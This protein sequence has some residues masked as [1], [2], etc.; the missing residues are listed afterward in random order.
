MQISSELARMF[1]NQ[2][3]REYH[4]ELSYRC[5]ADW[6]ARHGL[7]NIFKHLFLQADDEHGHALKFIHY[8]DEANAPLEVPAVVA[9]SSDYAD[10]HAIAV[11]RLELESSTKDEID[12]IMDAA[13]QEGDY[14]AQTFLQDMCL[15]QVQEVTESERFVAALECAGGAFLLDL[16]LK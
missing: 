1:N 5:M 10:C 9:A 3:S 2:I 11:A 14:G 15:E 16:Q 4:N 8:L 6:S 12:S 7:D 13:I